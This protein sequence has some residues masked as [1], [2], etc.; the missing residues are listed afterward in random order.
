MDREPTNQSMKSSFLQFF[1]SFLGASLAI[2]IAFALRSEPNERSPAVIAPTQVSA[3]EQHSFAIGADEQQVISPPP[4]LLSSL[5]N[6]NADMIG[7]KE[8]PTDLGAVDL[9]T[10]E[11]PSSPDLTTFIPADAEIYL[12]SLPRKEDSEPTNFGDPY[13]SADDE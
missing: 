13:L 6:E 1:S 5:K 4:S 3:V 11:D 9:Q 7:I 2:G 8:L 10:G 12:P